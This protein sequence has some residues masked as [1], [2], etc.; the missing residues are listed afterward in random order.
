MN[1]MNTL[2]SYTD[3]NGS[4]YRLSFADPLKTTCLNQGYIYDDL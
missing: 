4:V 1:M 3:I 2:W